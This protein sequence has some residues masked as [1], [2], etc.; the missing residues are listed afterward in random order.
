MIDSRCSGALWRPVHW[1]Q[2]PVP[3]A[4]HGFDETGRLGG[5]TKRGSELVDCCVEAPF[6]V[7]RPPVGPDRFADLFSRNENL[8]LA[9][10][11]GENA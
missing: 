9:K 10:Q 6:E 7:D 3:L 4:R 11:S 8:G 5:V 2:E 1:C